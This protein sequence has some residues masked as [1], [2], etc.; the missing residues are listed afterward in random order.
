MLVEFHSSQG[1]PEGIGK[2]FGPLEVSVSGECANLPDILNLFEH[3]LRGSGFYFKD[4][5]VVILSPGEERDA[6]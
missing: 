2:Q 4:G 6:D 5:E 3:F 1:D